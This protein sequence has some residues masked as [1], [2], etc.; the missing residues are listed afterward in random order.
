MYALMERSSQKSVG[1]LMLPSHRLLVLSLSMPESNMFLPQ[2]FLLIVRDIQ[3]YA[4]HLRKLLDTIVV[5]L[6]IDYQRTW[7]SAYGD[8]GSVSWSKVIANG[9]GDLEVSFPDVR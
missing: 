6:S 1:I 9:N 5:S 7:P 4:V 2:H 8:G 3:L